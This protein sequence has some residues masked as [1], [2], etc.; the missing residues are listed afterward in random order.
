MDVLYLDF[1]KDFNKVPIKRLI[2]K[3]AGLGIG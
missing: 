1:S 3:Y 2:A